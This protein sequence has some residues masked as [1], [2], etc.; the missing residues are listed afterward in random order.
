MLN[1]AIN[2]PS[3][4]NA[5]GAS[6]NTR[7]PSPPVKLQPNS[8]PLPNTYQ[9]VGHTLQAFE[10][11]EQENYSIYYG[12]T[13][14]KKGTESTVYCIDTAEAYYLDDNGVLRYM[15]DDKAAEETLKKC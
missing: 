6:T 4:R 10:E 11:F 8:D 7:M 2:S 14:I 9:I 12:K 15:S 13:C 1:K 5:P 3:T